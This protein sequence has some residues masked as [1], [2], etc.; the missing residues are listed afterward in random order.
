MK[1]VVLIGAECTGKSTLAKA[2]AEE[3]GEP[4]SD[5]FVRLYVE[6]LDRPL[7]ER[8]L[9]VIA[10]G[11]IRLEDEACAEASSF[12]VHDTSLLSSMVYAEHYFGSRIEWVDEAFEKR[13]YDFYFLC[14]PDF[15]WEA[16]P[17]QREGAAVRERLQGEFVSAL[18]RQGISYV[19]LSGSVEQR[20][21][22]VLEVI[23][24]S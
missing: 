16:D 5:E 10:R 6:G 4:C 13:C 1:R 9:E 12:V 18:E 11:Q 17:G 2:L 19:S 8:D 20:L 24:G 3:L 21:A 14:Q 7:A 23:R 15:P 22:R